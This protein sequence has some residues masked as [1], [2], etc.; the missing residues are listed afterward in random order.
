MKRALGIAV[1]LAAL[2]A[3]VVLSTGA[4]RDAGKGKYWV[5]FDNAFGLIQGGDL[6]IAGVRAGTITDIKLDQRTKRALIGFKITQNGFGSLR[7]DV[8]CE[9]RPQSLIGEYFID[10][11]PGTASRELK[12][13]TTIP[14]THTASTVAPDL[15]N[16]IL[17]RPYNERLSI[18][19]SS[20]G[21]G[22]AGNAEALNAAVRRASPA[23]RETDKTLAILARQNQILGDLAQN[24]DRV[25]GDLNNNRKDVGRWIVEAR[26]TATASAQRRNDIAAGFKRLPGFLA[27]LQPAMKALGDVAD[28]QT[29]ALRNL[30]ASSKDLTT[31]FNRL[32]PFS[33]ASRPAIR[34]LG[35]ASATG[36]R[37][38]K[39]AVPTVN[40]LNRFSQGTPE[41][42]KNLAIVLQHLD[43]RKYAVE[44]DPRS[45]GGKGY[46]GLE[47]LLTYVYDQTLS[48]NV[49]DQNNHILKL[50]LIAGGNCVKYADIARAKKFA[51]ECASALGPNQP[52]INFPDTTEFQKMDP[53]ARA[54]QRRINGDRQTPQANTPAPGALDQG[55]S[56]SSAPQQDGK[57]PV[58]VPVQ[59]PS[60]LPPLPSVPGVPPVQLPKTLPGVTNQD[61][62]RGGGLVG[63]LGLKASTR[64]TDPQA[65]ARLL[66]YLLAP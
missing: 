31:F 4:G 51:A 61:T 52:G 9:S 38:L 17:R 41:L 15:V 37:A 7:T 54:A 66:D 62:P 53:Q 11:L 13:G 56:Q 28:Q 29:P 47:A 6:K 64:T 16:N 34:S 14:V 59:P 33:D 32:A 19:L 5:E 12:P 36:D 44:D 65:Q 45:P 60:Q 20:L 42:A 55:P 40:E 18:I 39:A 3:F 25:I 46:T 49:F 50:A 30:D 23:L 43:D 58:Q 26:N 35:N 2:A 22:V 24:A 21:A 63:G 57:P 48:T 1:A 8:H 10:C 27:Q